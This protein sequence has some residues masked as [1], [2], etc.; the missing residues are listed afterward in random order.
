MD[1]GGASPLKAVVIADE[2][3]PQLG[4]GGSQSV[5][6]VVVTPTGKIWAVRHNGSILGYT[7]SA[8]EG[9]VIG[10]GLVDWLKAQGRKAE[11]VVE[12]GALH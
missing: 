10:E 3:T 6:A 4:F 7:K 2:R 8:A 9:A 11:L 12:R 1:S 5:E